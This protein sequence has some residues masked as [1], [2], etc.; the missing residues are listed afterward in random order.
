[1]R[2]TGHIVGERGAVVTLARQHVLTQAEA[3]EQ[4]RLSVRQGRRLV[5]RVE[6]ARGDLAT[7]AY[8]RQHPA[9]NRL[10]EEVRLAVQELAAAHPAWS[11]PAVWEAVA[12]R[13]VAP[14]PGVRT[15]QR[16]L[17]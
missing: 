1:M 13:A 10:S 17:Q 7:L 6:S 15:V 4:L 14:L 5:R 2:F 3:A 16:W 11:A 12:S 9:P 8:R